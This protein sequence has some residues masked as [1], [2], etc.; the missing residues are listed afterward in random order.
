MD[1]DTTFCTLLPTRVS[2]SIKFS[3]GRPILLLITGSRE[4]SF[5]DRL[6][7]LQE[8]WGSV[9]LLL[10]AAR[11]G[12]KHAGTHAGQKPGA[13]KR[14]H[15]GLKLSNPPALHR[16]RPGE[17]G[18]GPRS[19]LARRTSLYARHPRH[20]ASWPPLD[21]APVRWLWHRRGHQPALSLSPLAGAN[22]PVD[23]L[24]SAHADGLRFRS[25]LERRRSRQVRRG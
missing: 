14:I 23:R 4:R 19:G 11:L 2:P 1:G 21:H 9:G 17:L 10:A 5:H 25:R 13:P 18:S 8:I 12:E 20:H 24:R 6:F 22:R 15:H 7:Q 3:R 16:K